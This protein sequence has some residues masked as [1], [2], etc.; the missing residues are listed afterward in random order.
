M[1]VTVTQSPHGYSLAGMNYTL[2][3]VTT[4]PISRP[5]AESVLEA[6][7]VKKGARKTYMREYRKLPIGPTN[8]SGQKPQ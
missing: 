5:K 8:G 7:W 4:F 1:A 6:Y 2:S 3:V